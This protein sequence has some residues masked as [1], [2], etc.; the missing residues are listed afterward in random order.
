[1]QLI[2][3]VADVSSGSLGV[4]FAAGVFDRGDGEGG[5]GSG[6]AFPASR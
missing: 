3:Q 4:G 1:M 6:G 5:R 2:K